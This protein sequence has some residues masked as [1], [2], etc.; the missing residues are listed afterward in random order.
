MTIQMND[1]HLKKRVRVN[2]LGLEGFREEH[3]QVVGAAAARRVVRNGVIYIT[4]WWFQI[5]FIFT[6]SPA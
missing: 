1:E 6:T 3:R 5:F 4:R 2:S